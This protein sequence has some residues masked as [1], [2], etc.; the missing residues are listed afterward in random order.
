[1]DKE[2]KQE[3]FE[4]QV[5]RGFCALQKNILYLFEELRNDNLIGNDYF[6][7]CRKRVLD[8]SNDT[9]RDLMEYREKLLS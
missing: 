9:K 4:Y 2:K 3:L 5:N 6:Q 1:M 7:R 8:V